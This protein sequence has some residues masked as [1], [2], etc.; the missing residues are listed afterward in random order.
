MSRQVG[1]ENAVLGRERGRKRAPV[2]DRSAEP[3]HEDERRTVTAGRV[4]EPRS[5]PLELPF[6]ESLQPVFAVRHH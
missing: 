4:M 5:A 1:N 3:V 6:L 2:L